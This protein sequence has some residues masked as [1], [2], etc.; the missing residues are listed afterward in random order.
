MVG[1]KESFREYTAVSH[2][3]TN[4]NYELVVADGL[5]PQIAEL[6]PAALHASVALDHV[7]NPLATIT[8]ALAN[9]ARL[10]QPTQTLH[11]GAHGRSGAFF[12]GGQWVTAATLIE[13]AQYLAQWQVERIALWSCALGSDQNFVSLL[14]ELTGA[15]VFAA[16]DYLGTFAGERNWT[17]AS[18]DG[19][20]LRGESVFSK[21][22][23]D[24]WSGHL[25]TKVAVFNQAGLNGNGV[26][27]SSDENANLL[28]IVQ[29]EIDNGADYEIE[30]GI[31]S[32]TIADLDTRLADA[33][34]FFMTDMENADPT[35]N[36]FLPEAAVDILRDFV[37]GGGVMVMTGTGGKDDVDFLN[38]IF[39]WDLG[40]T[41]GGPWN[42]DAAA[43]VGT[44][45]E[46]GPAS[47]TV[48]D[49]TDSISR[50]TVENFTAIYGDET[51][52][53]VAV[54]E[55][56]LGTV[57]FQG[58]DFFDSGFANDFG[59]GTHADGDQNTDD[60]VT[61]I[62][63][64]SLEYA[65]S[66]AVNGA[67]RITS[68][69]TASVEENA[70]SVLTVTADDAEDDALTFALIG[71]A[72]QALFTVD[73]TTGELSFNSAP[74]FELPSDANGDNTYEVE[75][76]VDDGNGG[77]TTQAVSVSV[78]DV[79][80]SESLIQFNLSQF[81]SELE[82][83]YFVVDDPSG[84]IDG[85]APGDAGYLEAALEQSTLLFSALPDDATLLSDISATS[86]RSVSGGGYLSFF[87]IDGSIN[88]FLDSGEGTIS[89]L[90]VKD[91]A[92][93]ASSDFS[94]DINGIT[95]SATE[96]DALP[97]GVGLQGNVDANII[98]LT[99]ITEPVSAT[100]T[101]QREAVFDNVVG[102]YVID[103]LTGLVTD[104]DGNTFVPGDSGYTAAALGQRIADISL[105][106]GNNST[107]QFSA[108]L[109]A[110]QII[111]P[112]LV[113]DGT[114]EALLDESTSNDPQIYFPF[115][116]AN[117]DG[118][119]HMRLFGDNT[120]GFE[121]MVGG[122]DL[123]FDDVL[124]RMEFA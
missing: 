35:N 50:G 118:V 120:I 61:E 11:V 37:E 22:A 88:S 105:S 39:G 102:F 53:T 70:T 104:A 41:G 75:V 3:P 68:E 93:V 18:A 99:Q 112:F 43:A 73:S 2:L 31:T 59:E 82:I 124:I 72:D 86:T 40:S 46:G 65:R 95:L 27:D 9:R 30:L 6:L 113:V 121:D 91:I 98:D 10:G 19:N 15:Q 34:F 96:T 51:N 33:S 83:G 20:T 80:E 32:F 5:C 97:I 21:T 25:A 111:A 48:A 7:S 60:W 62:L 52:A 54:I 16:A 74:D 92:A 100:F 119:D 67:P 24:T 58:F 38:R 77:V 28:S 109:E 110:N 116:G 71:G 63:P 85:L 64:R 81:S 115:L 29:N 56:G 17:I 14:A 122:G 42:L 90:D 84:T 79:D 69:A 76:S 103:D 47:L 66:L 123:D 23:I 26:G 44:P 36:A 87:S 101:V 55:F 4:I 106:A 13:N 1:F 8:E 45:F 12:M 57:I 94:L 89:L 117:S 107:A 78:T 108:T 49:A 114:L